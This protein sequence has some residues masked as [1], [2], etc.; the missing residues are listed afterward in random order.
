MTVKGVLH[1]WTEHAKGLEK[2]I[3]EHDIIATE[4]YATSES[5]DEYMLKTFIG[6]KG[7]EIVKKKEKLLTAIDLIDKEAEDININLIT[8]IALSIG[9]TFISEKFPQL[10]PIVTLGAIGGS[11]GGMT[12][13]L[14]LYELSRKNEKVYSVFSN[15]SEYLLPIT[16][17]FFGMSEKRDIGMAY[18]IQKLENKDY[19][20]FAVVGLGH[21]DKIKKLLK[22]P[23]KLEK[24]Y[25]EYKHD[26]KRKYLK[27]YRYYDDFKLVDKIKL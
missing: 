6:E 22:N 19:K 18:S 24:L 15:L 1:F 14:T 2:Y 23:E 12:T 26:F 9:V 13:M 21:E 27:I 17:I 16:Y 3:E 20:T 25:Q 7:L 8:P 11:L 4:G 10:K 5:I